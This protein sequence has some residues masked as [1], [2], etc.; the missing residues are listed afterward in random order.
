MEIFQ[1]LNEQGIT[2]VLVTHE[3]D[4]AQYA[5]R[6]ISFKDGKVVQDSIIQHRVRASEILKTLPVLEEE[7]AV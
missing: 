5:G 3:Q 4:I 7:S 6:I 2:I 1:R